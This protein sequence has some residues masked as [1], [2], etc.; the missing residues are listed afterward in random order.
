MPPPDVKQ[1]MDAFEDAVDPLTWLNGFSELLYVATG[2]GHREWL[3]YS[4]DQNRFM[5]ELND[6][7]STHEPYPLEIEFGDD[8]EWKAWSELAEAVE[9]R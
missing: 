8:P 4:S 2:S 7:L 3:F 6:L 5:R 1:A 9:E